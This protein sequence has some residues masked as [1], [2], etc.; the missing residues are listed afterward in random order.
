MLLGNIAIQ[1]LKG[2]SVRMWNGPLDQKDPSYVV[3]DVVGV[4]E[5][6]HIPTV[7]GLLVR[8]G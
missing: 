7:S 3:V 1:K 8:V 2:V 6:Y 5:E 4:F